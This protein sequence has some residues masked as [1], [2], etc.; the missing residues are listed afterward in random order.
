MN[1]HDPHTRPGAHLVYERLGASDAQD[2]AG[3]HPYQSP[4]A[5]LASVVAS[6]ARDVDRLHQDLTEQAKTV[7]ERLQPIARGDHASMRGVNGII[8]SAGLQVELLTARRGAAYGQLDKVLGA[9]ERGAETERP[10][11]APQV[12]RDSAHTNGATAPANR[13]ARP[14][15]TVWDDE[16]GLARTALR[17]MEHGD[18]WLRESVHGDKHVIWGSG[19]G[20]PIEAE[21]VERLIGAGLVAVNT[22]TSASRMGHMLSLTPEGV[23]AGAAA[24][25]ERLR[26]VAALYRT[27]TPTAAGPAQAVPSPG[28]AQPSVSTR[29]C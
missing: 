25:T 7:I 11:A 14:A 10:T 28:A 6:C 2:L 17:Q 12:R 4:L 3:Q 24:R 9:Y 29:T 15:T 18:L 20:A 22:N 13:Q 21:T 19:L 27:I 16:Q 23:A 26:Q 8:Q 1:P 5:H